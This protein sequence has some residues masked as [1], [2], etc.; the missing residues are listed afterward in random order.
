MVYVSEIGVTRTVVLTTPVYFVCFIP[1][2]IHRKLRK[3]SFFVFNIAY[4]KSKEVCTWGALGGG[5]GIDF[6]L[7]LNGLLRIHTVDHV[8]VLR[9]YLL[10]KVWHTV[11]GQSCI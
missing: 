11:L 9:V 1:R 8:K 3:K 2:A 5:G 4:K 10:C 7:S 6:L